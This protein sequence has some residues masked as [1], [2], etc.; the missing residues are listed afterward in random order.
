MIPLWW[1]A[2]AWAGD[3]PTKTS[4]S[5]NDDFEIRYWREPERLPDFED[6]R[7]LDY[8]E[9]VNR[10]NANLVTGR[11]SF[12]LQLDEVALFANRYTLD[13]EQVI[14]RDLT[15]PGL[16]SIFPPDADI[17][18]NP[19]KVRML[20]EAPAASVALGDSYVAFGRGAAI[21]LNRNVDIDIDTSVQGAK[22]VLRPGAW[23][24]SLVAG[25]ANRQQ[26]YQ[27]N[28]NVLIRGDIRHT[29]AGLRAERFGLGPANIGAH[30]V[31]YDFVQDPG[32]EA[33]FQALG[34]PPDA[35][36][37]G[38][39]TELVGVAGVDWFVEGDLFHYGP[40]H[41]VGSLGEDAP[42]TG[43]ALYGSA[44]A[45]PGPFVVLLEGK[46]YY[47]ADRL[48]EGVSVIDQ[49]EVAVAPTLEYE[50]MITED[51]QATLNSNDIVGGRVGVDWAVIPGILVPNASLAVFY[52]RDLGV[53]HVNDVPETVVHPILGVEWIDGENAVLA[54]AGYRS[55]LR[56][57][58]RGDRHLH[59]DLSWNFPLPG[60]FVG[61][62][63]AYAER[64]MWGENPN[65]AL[66]QDDY[67][68]AETSVTCTWATI[69][70]L[71]AFVDVSTD[72]LVISDGGNLSEELFGSV[73]LQVKP[74]D[75]W[76]IKA[77][78][79]A[80]KAGIRCA[81][82]QCRYLPGFDGARASVV[83]TF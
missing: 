71:S 2:F 7:V 51:S 63:N 13:G 16:P 65:A 47:Q 79:G 75:A 48:N 9:Q 31:L 24:L 60:D 40:D 66:Q 45:Y 38:L 10:L 20:Y 14:E 83:G 62:V 17:Y 32:W 11:W 72:R 33:G 5:F 35:L 26:V 19:E 64:F 22:V 12:G 21:N 37:G 80:Q 15:A 68:E 28:P 27:D 58:E 57:N 77:F 41:P 54:N 49:Y 81:G 29:I 46:R 76:T 3:E 44:A 43:Y 6:L 30:G 34:E 59:G 23:D 52:D 36:V 4:V 61:N 1:G 39:T 25:Q 42:E 53:L 73:E 82:G 69:V 50:R 67:T 55:D 56:E 70:S 18:V 74:A 78:F 8:V